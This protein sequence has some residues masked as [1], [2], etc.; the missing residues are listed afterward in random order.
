MQQRGLES[1]VEESVEVLSRTEQ[2]RT[3]QN[4]M[5]YITDSR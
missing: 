4:R 3:E 5:G 1:S 2:S